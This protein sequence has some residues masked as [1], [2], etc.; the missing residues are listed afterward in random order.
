MPFDCGRTAALRYAYHSQ[1]ARHAHGVSVFRILLFQRPG[2]HYT[3]SHADGKVP[4][5]KR[6]G[7]LIT[8][9]G[10]DGTGKSTQLRLLAGWLR[11]R[12]YRPHVTREP[13]G[14]RVGEQIRSVLLASSNRKLTAWSELLLMYAARHQHLEEVVRPALRRGELVL[15]DRFNDSSFA[16]Q[17]YGRKLGK[18]PV[19]IVD[20]Q[21]CGSTQPDLT[22][23]LDAPP[24]LAL[25][26]ATKRGK[27]ATDS[28]FEN[29][30]LRFQARVRR[31]YLAIAH[32]Q[33]GR[34][35]IVR[36]G[37]PANDVQAE[38]REIV[39]AFL[40]RRLHRRSPRKGTRP[41][42]EVP[43]RAERVNSVAC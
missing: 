43:R 16:Y 9:E 29:E 24:R 17:G 39:G 20:A 30:G 32:E 23:I 34:V 8:L 41:P 35:K 4:S 21:V 27:A 1:G 14:T 31:G 18:R 10:T 15:S 6:R 42:E 11:R 36:A 5:L 26:R 13:G 25:K 2:F 28:R 3:E 37:L 40:A 22:I 19:E 7:V 38:I 12:G 33:P